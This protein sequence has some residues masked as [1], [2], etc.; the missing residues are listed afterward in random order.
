MT[1][2]EEVLEIQTKHNIL[3]APAE[4]P[5]VDF[6]VMA[7]AATNSTLNINL[8]NNTKSS[9]VWAYIT[10]LNVNQ[11]NRVWL[12]RSDGVT[13]Y[14]PESPSRDQTPLPADCAISLGGP[15]S[16]R[17]VT[18]PHII[19]GRIW[20]VPDSKLTFL[21]NIGGN[22]PA[23]VEPSA[24][25]PNDP[26]YFLHWGFAE[27][28]FN[29]WECFA[30]VTYVDFVGSQPVSL[31]L[32]AENNQTQLV[33]GLPAGG[34]DGI[35]QELV[36]QNNKD[37]AGWDRLIVKGRQGENLRAVHPTKMMD[38][39][40]GLF[41]GYWRPYVDAVW[42]KYS[43]QDLNLNT[44][45][46]WG[47]VK[48][49]VQNSSLVFGNIASIPKPSDKDIFACAGG[50]FTEWDGP[51]RQQLG[52]IIARLSA[53]FNRSTLLINTNQPDGERLENYYKDPI[54]NHYCRIV[55]AAHPDGR[56]YTFAYDDV[57]PNDASNVAGTVVSGQPKLL[58]VS[59]GNVARVQGFKEKVKLREI[60]RTGGRA[61][62]L[63]GFGRRVRR[64][65][66]MESQGEEMSEVAVAFGEKT[67]DAAYT[68]EEQ[69]LG[70][71]PVYIVE[72]DAIDLEKGMLRKLEAETAWGQD[73]VSPRQQ[74]QQMLEKIL[75]ESVREKIDAI[76]EKMAESPAYNKY[77]RP[78]LETL[79]RLLVAI[80]SL[81][82][83]TL[84][85]RA[86]MVLLLVGCSFFLGFFGHGASG[87]GA[88]SL[89]G[90]GVD[91]LVAAPAVG[92]VKIQIEKADAPVAVLHAQEQGKEEA[93]L[94]VEQTEEKK[95]ED[96]SVKV[97]VDEVN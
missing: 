96:A 35:C 3:M 36:N 72:R 88:A 11:N 12:L 28:T 51:N 47:Q 85:S 9:N 59:F 10:G 78:V 31:A 22:G 53:A 95:D 83:K 2:L 70:T 25:A 74:E 29:S 90:V 8:Q 42:Q 84:V 97:K 92:E 14:M 65:L 67:E 79:G 49:R 46:Q 66:E 16:S 32:T 48:G 39:Q 37:R 33:P 73:A 1:T 94:M 81:S 26:N 19:G 7:A 80:L 17:T 15:G 18:I 38:I 23:L 58:T 86:V 13:G 57:A 62:Q 5:R 87:A 45:V 56:G 68:D 82:F 34:L 89:M 27:L 4:N 24:A 91:G 43:N 60:S 93:V 61:N 64:G 55:H 76:L 20:F 63:V 69:N 41:N 54:T 30:N 50:A 6:K 21:L 75:P 52:N 71:R 77:A 40:P 44:Q